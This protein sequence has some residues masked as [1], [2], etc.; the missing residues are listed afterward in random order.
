MSQVSC[1]STGPQ[2]HHSQTHSH[3]QHTHTCWLS[4]VVL[5]RLAVEAAGHCIQT[6]TRTQ[7]LPTTTQRPRMMWHHPLA[8][9]CCCC[10]RCLLA[11]TGRTNTLL[12]H[13]AHPISRCCCVL[14]HAST[15]IIH[16]DHTLCCLITAATTCLVTT[17]CGGISCAL[18]A[19]A[20]AAGHSVTAAAASGQ[21]VEQCSCQS[22]L[23]CTA[24]INVKAVAMRKRLQK[25][26][27]CLC[28]CC[29]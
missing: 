18:A 14:R 23:L 13:T 12:L 25:P 26:R 28:G 22:L 1:V 2:P 3:T 21:A 16:A 7:P 24:H 11:A 27:Y 15:Q 19:A 8:L 10:C 9:C 29:C 17:S 20:T 5:S 4:W 6:H